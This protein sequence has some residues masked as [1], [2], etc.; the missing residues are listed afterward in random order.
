MLA[1]VISI[2]VIGRESRWYRRVP[3]PTPM[4][5]VVGPADNQ[6]H[7]C[8]IL[9]LAD[10]HNSMN[11]QFRW[12]RKFY[13][14][15]TFNPTMTLSMPNVYPLAFSR[16]RCCC[17]GFLEVGCHIRVDKTVRNRSVPNLLQ[18]VEYFLR[19]GWLYRSHAKFWHAHYNT[20][21]ILFG[22]IHDFLDLKCTTWGLHNQ[23]FNSL[24]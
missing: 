14:W 19:Y 7:L 24:R 22:P 16:F 10:R 6:S 23:H 15:V 1:H 20:K 18:S 5:S 12:V 8:C 21:S 2:R 3:D 17:H 9:L 4:A 13:A 11:E